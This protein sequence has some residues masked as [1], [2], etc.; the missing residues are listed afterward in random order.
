MRM[1]HHTSLPVADLES[2]SR[3][4]DAVLGALGYRQVCTSSGFIGYGIEDNKDQF[5]I[6]QI[7]PSSTAGACSHLAFNAPTRE[8]VDLFHVAALDTGGACNGAPGLRKHY[9]PDY[10]A[11]FIIDLDGHR[12]EAVTSEPISV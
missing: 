8:A 9:G 11:A 7:N 6:M 4:Y 12:L 3:F 5:S 1:I 10:Y 2:S